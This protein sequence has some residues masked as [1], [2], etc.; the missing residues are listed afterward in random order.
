[1]DFGYPYTLEDVVVLPSSFLREH[2]EH[3][4]A[5]TLLHESLHID[6]RADQARYDRFYVRE[7]GYMRPKHLKFRTESGSGQS[8]TLMRLTSNG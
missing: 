2:N 5:V 1:M 6:Q 8:L 3:Q 7:W 4:A